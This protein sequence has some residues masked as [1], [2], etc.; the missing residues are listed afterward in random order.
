MTKKEI[1][2]VTGISFSAFYVVIIVLIYITFP[3][4]TCLPASNYVS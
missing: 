3:R 2:M 4:K 1:K